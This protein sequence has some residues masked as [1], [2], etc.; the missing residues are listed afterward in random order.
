MTKCEVVSPALELEIKSDVKKEK[1]EPTLKPK[2]EELGNNDV[3]IN[4]PAIVLKPKQYIVPKSAAQIVQE[5][6]GK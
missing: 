2:Q 3:K 4:E 5:Q 6:H 1:P